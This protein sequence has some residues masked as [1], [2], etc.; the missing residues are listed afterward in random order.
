VGLVD[1]TDGHFVDSLV[2]VNPRIEQRIGQRHQEEED[3]YSLILDDALHLLTPD[4]AD[5]LYTLIYTM[6]YRHR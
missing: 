2:V 5:I 4:V 3:K 6:E 1:H